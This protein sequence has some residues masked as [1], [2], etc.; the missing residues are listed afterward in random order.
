MNPSDSNELNLVF[1][2]LDEKNFADFKLLHQ[3]IFPVKYSVR[4]IT[5]GKHLC[6]NE[7]SEPWIL[8][9]IKSG[10]ILIETALYM[11][12]HVSQPRIIA[13][14]ILQGLQVIGKCYPSR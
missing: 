7:A 3:V 14:S 4:H 2:S 10:K 12:L 8:D 11:H 5:S 9:L 13:G 1:R 6:T